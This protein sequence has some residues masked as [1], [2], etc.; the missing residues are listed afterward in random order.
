M[1]DLLTKLGIGGGSGF[2]GIVLGWLGFKSKIQA[3]EK[4]IDEIKKEAR[5]TITCIAVHKA[6]DDRLLSI[7]TMQREMR[8][9]IKRLIKR[10]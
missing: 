6:V 8:D 10:R 4:D 2:V 9:D 3:L 5:Y 1:D 7:E